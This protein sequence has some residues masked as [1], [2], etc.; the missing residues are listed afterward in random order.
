MKFYFLRLRFEGAA[1]SLINNCLKPID[2]VLEKAKL[3]PDDIKLVRKL[4][5]VLN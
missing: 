4:F 3:Q 5:V 2:S 1:S